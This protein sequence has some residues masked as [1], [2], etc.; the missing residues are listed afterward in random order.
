MKL[1]NAFYLVLALLIGATSWKFL[2][3]IIAQNGTSVISSMSSDN[4]NG[5]KP[6]TIKLPANLTNKQFEMLN[7]AYDVAKSDGFKE[8]KYLQGIIMQESKAGSMNSYRV[9]G[10]KNSVGNRYFGIMQ[11]KL[12]AAMDVMKSYPE[13]W[14]DFDTKTNEELQAK[15]ILDDKF[16]IR[17]GSKYLLMRGINTNPSIAITAYNQGEQGAKMVNNTSF[18]YTV[19]VKN[20]AQRFASL[21]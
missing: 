21:Q 4:Q 19:K 5:N 1:I 11:L 10:L 16:N 3:P 13:L 6:I 20:Y 14:K 9:A 12:A 15:L 18:H 2:E 17:V 8:P 7:F